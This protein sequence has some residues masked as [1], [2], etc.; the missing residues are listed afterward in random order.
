MR[1]FG[2][3]ENCCDLISCGMRACS[4]ALLGPRPPWAGRRVAARAAPRAGVVAAA[5][6]H[7]ARDRSAVSRLGC[8]CAAQRP[9]RGVRSSSRRAAHD[10][11]RL[12]FCRPGATPA[13]GG[14]RRGAGG[15]NNTA[16]ARR[17]LSWR[18]RRPRE[19]TTYQRCALRLTLH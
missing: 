15:G 7:A 19:R 8:C 16:A 11:P 6:T 5:G 2:T 1:R 4:W 10:P 3:Q 18:R 13:A 17:R 9:P 14:R 12:S